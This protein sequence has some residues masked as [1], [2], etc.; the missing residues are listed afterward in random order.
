MCE[1]C[2]A[3][4]PE[5]Y[6]HCRRCD[7]CIYLMDHHCNWVGNC[8]GHFN[9][10][11]YLHLLANILLHSTLVFLLILCNYAHLF[12][13]QQYKIYFLIDLVPSLYSIYETQRLLNDFRLSV[14]NN[15][16]LI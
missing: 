2:R 8:I 7:K 5:R 13:I 10:K 9:Y 15:Q 12:D 14:K 3:V 6:Y 16:T 4:K 1:V 11:V